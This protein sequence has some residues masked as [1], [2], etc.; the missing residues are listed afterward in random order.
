LKS[1]VPGNQC[2]GCGCYNK[3]VVETRIKCK[4]KCDVLCSRNTKVNVKAYLDVSMLM[5][6]MAGCVVYE[7]DVMI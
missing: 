1:V 4:A 3:F 7:S 6:S 2:I 5:S